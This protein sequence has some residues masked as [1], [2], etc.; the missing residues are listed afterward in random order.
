MAGTI[1]QRATPQKYMYLYDRENL[2][3]T[4]GHFFMKMRIHRRGTNCTDA[5]LH[6]FKTSSHVNDTKDDVTKNNTL[7]CYVVSPGSIA[8][9][10]SGPSRFHFKFQK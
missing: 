2:K 7:M 10:S 4:L 9:E 8:N 3:G 5:L 6:A 1:K